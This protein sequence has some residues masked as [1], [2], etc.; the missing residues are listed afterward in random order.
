MDHEVE[1]FLH[2][3]LEP[4]IE[5]P[6]TTAWFAVRFTKGEY[7]IFDAFPDDRSRFAH[8]TGRVPRELAKHGLQRLGGVPEIDSNGVLASKLPS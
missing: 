1:E 5:E 2:S 4:V 8:L 7:A 6:A 3:A